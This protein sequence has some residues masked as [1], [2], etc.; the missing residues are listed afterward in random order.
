MVKHILRTQVSL[1]LLRGETH[2]EDAIRSETH[3]E[4]LCI[5]ANSVN[6]ETHF[7]DPGIPVLNN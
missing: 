6:G 4:D 2:L 5:A 7:E 1:N 3:F